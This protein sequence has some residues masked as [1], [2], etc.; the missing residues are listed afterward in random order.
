MVDR[1][2][3]LRHD[4]VVGGDHQHD[5][6][7]GVGT[8]GTHLRE[9]G[10]TR[11]VEERDRAVLVHHLVGADVLGD[12]TGL[13]V[14]DV[15]AADVVEQRGLAVVDV[16]HHGDHRR[17]RLLALV[18]V[19]VVEQLL[20]LDLFLLTGLDQEDLGADLEREQLHLLV[21]ERHRGRD[22]LAVV[23]QEADDVGRRAVQLR[24]ELL[25]RHTTLDDDDA[26]RE[27]VHPRTCRS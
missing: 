2:D 3:R 7:G 5:D 11:G 24:S 21:G 12:A 22:H 23:E 20:Q 19:G 16:T 25:R 10:V 15:G 1:L 6:V 26:G 8:T 13:T 4:A 17:T 18:V 14:D 27:P 9:R